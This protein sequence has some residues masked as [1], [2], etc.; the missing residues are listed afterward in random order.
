M[1]VEKIELI[2]KSTQCVVRVLI[3]Y[4][5]SVAKVSVKY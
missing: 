1:R 3:K 2:N 5:L 4:Q